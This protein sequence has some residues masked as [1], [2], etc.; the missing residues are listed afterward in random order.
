MTISENFC[1]VLGEA[2]INA[3]PRLKRG[4]FVQ[5]VVRK[6]G[7]LVIGLLFKAIQEYKQNE[8]L[9]KLPVSN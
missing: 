1:Q 8:T 2:I 3:P 9:H 7:E 4:I 6:N 5:C